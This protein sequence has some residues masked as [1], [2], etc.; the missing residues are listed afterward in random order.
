MTS[1]KFPSSLSGRVIELAKLIGSLS[2]IAGA[3]LTIWSVTWG[4]ARELVD[5]VVAEWTDMQESVAE[6]HEE[7]DSLRKE[8]AEL[9]GEDRVIREVPGLTYVA[10]PVYQGERIV[11]NFVAE[12]TR[13]GEKCLFRY[14]QPIFTDMFNI[15]TPGERRQAARQISNDPTPLRPGYTP[16]VNLRPGRVTVY[17]ILAYTCAGEEVFDQTSTAAF[18]LL[19]GPRPAD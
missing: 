10:E 8:V 18:E 17:L 2:V 9:K 5:Y 12:R 13:L 11:F 6:I 14:S 1:D 16:P 4:P 7:V 19:E 3:I 15:P